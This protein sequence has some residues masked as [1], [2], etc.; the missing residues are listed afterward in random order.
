MNRIPEFKSVSTNT[1]LTNSK[2]N[3]TAKLYSDSAKTVIKKVAYMTKR[4]KNLKL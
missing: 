3:L 2:S 1:R 4:D